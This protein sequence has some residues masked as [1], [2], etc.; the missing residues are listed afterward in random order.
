MEI[1]FS[2]LT[3]ENEIR[4]FSQFAQFLTKLRFHIFLGPRGLPLVQEKYETA[5]FSIFTAKKWTF[6]FQFQ[7]LKMRLGIILNLLNF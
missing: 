6:I 2:I 4:H 5:T 3:P 1:Y 7:P